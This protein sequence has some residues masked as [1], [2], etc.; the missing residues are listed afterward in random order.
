MQLALSGVEADGTECEVGLQSLWDSNRAGQNP[1]AGEARRHSFQV[2][3][4]GFSVMTCQLTAS[5]FFLFPETLREATQ[6]IC[7]MYLCFSK[8]LNRSQE[9]GLQNAA[10]TCGIDAVDTV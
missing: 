1:V 10:S 9:V 5:A 2:V 7:D 3:L 8:V 4:H 6:V